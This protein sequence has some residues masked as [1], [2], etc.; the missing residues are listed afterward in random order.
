MNIVIC[1]DE[2]AHDIGHFANDCAEKAKEFLDD[3]GRTIVE[4]RSDDLTAPNIEA[5]IME[6]N[7]SNFVF[8]AFSHGTYCTLE[9]LTHGSYISRTVNHTLFNN[10]FFYTWSCSCAEDFVNFLG[11][12]VF[13]G[14]DCEVYA[15]SPGAENYEIFLECALYG[16]KIF[17]EDDVSAK[18]AFDSMVEHYDEKIAGLSAEDVEASWKLNK[19]R[20]GLCFDGDENSTVNDFVLQ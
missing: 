20:M 9:S 16:L 5:T 10:S 3:L 8:T 1:W 19:N 18:E 12:K 14:Y 2:D 4:I 15:P 13:I 17:F 7:Q 11:Y 6:V